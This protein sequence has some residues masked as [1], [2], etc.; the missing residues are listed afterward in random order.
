MSVQLHDMEHYIHLLEVGKIYSFTTVIPT[1]IHQ[2]T[3]WYGN[4]R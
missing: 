4:Q 1:D 2:A 3:V